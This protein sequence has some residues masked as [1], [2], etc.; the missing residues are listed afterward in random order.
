MIYDRQCWLNGFTTG[1]LCF[2]NNTLHNHTHTPMSQPT[3]A[4][5]RPCFELPL[6]DAITSLAVESNVGFLFHHHLFSLC[7][8]SGASWQRLHDLVSHLDTAAQPR[9]NLLWM[10]V[11]GWGTHTI[12]E[13][14][15]VETL[16]KDTEM[17]CS[18][19]WWR[20]CVHACGLG[21]CLRR[22][23]LCVCVSVCMCVAETN[24]KRKHGRRINIFLLSSFRLPVLHGHCTR[25]E[26]KLLENCFLQHLFKLLK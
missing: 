11:V 24:D 2:W 13:R 14:F 21:E 1:G 7:V 5:P 3:T 18:L 10:G 6:S 16:E 12:V 19:M 23:F 22:Q 20:V 15:P 4:W 17:G 9:K 8:L 26:K 25:W